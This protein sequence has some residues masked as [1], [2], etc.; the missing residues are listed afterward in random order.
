MQKMSKYLSPFKTKIIISIVLIFLIAVIQCY[1]PLFEGKQ[2]LDFINNKENHK[3]KQSYKAH[4][5]FFKYKC[6]FI[7]IMRNR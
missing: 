3:D 4:I 6:Y 1:I 7:F 5:L 2:I